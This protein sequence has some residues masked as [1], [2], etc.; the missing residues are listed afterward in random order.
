MDPLK[1]LLASSRRLHPSAG[2]LFVAQA[3]LRSR[4]TAAAQPAATPA[5]HALGEPADAPQG[6]R[7]S[8]PAAG[9]PALSLLP[10]LLERRASPVVL[11]TEEADGH[12][13]LFAWRPS[14]EPNAFL[15][16][17]GGSGSGKTELLRVVGAD[18]AGQG[19][20]VLVLDLHGDLGKLPG[21]ARK[22]LG[23]TLGINPLGSAGGSAAGRSLL[24]LLAQGA[25]DL[26]HVQQALLRQSLQELAAARLG[27]RAPRLGDLK[28]ALERLQEGPERGPARGLLH[29]LDAI[30]DEPV[31]S[32]A[33]ELEASTL[34]SGSHSLDLSGLSRPAQ[35]V[36]AGAILGQ[37]FDRLY[38]AGPVARAG[39]LRLF[40]VL[41]EAA[42]LRNQ[43]LVEQLAKEARKFGIGLALATQEIRDVPASLQSNA[44]SAAVF[45]VMSRAEARQAAGLLPGV[46]PAD[47][48]A[49]P[50]PGGAI[51]RDGRGLH[52]L[53]VRPLRRGKR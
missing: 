52:K 40:V 46:E 12:T 23:A 8:G 7:A 34:L 16:I 36:A 18:L 41:D 5:A 15:L 29:A 2:R 39:A 10:K 49:L 9:T 35:V 42:P 27:G 38:S 37:L 48:Q 31:F 20:P 3:A 30:F 19:V 43:P 21:L 14:G 1:S 53:Q 11:G 6:S 33:S 4:A 13:Q 32:A 44:S 25:P 22:Q 17:T 50:A 47:L 24:A 51:F 28:R 45:R 26:G